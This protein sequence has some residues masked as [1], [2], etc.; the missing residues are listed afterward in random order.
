M[1]PTL[2]TVEDL[3]RTYEA[4]SVLKKVE[5]LGSEFAKKRYMELR[6]RCRKVFHSEYFGHQID[7]LYDRDQPKAL[8]V[9]E[10][11]TS[12]EQGLHKVAVV[13]E[14]LSMIKANIKKW[15]VC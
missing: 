6:P 13:G 4:E 11:D 5:I 8:Y 3:G 12:D 9:C 15:V 2:Q 7:R 10:F 1:T 14:S